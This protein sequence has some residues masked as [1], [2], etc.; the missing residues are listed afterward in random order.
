MTLDT[1]ATLY[2]QT[3]K[4]YHLCEGTAREGEAIDA[5]AGITLQLQEVLVEQHSMTAEEATTFLEKQ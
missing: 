4:L 1:I 5:W 3:W 2:R